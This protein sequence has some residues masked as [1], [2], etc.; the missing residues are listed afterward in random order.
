TGF[1]VI[2]IF[3]VLLRF[4]LPFV[5]SALESVLTHLGLTNWDKNAFSEFFQL[6]SNLASITEE[7]PKS[8]YFAY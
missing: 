5:K 4:I 7:S 6:R 8:E 1:L 2:A 3:G